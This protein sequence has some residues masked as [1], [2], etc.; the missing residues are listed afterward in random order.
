M[1]RFL[2]IPSIL[3]ILSNSSCAE[4]PPVVLTDAA[5][6]LHADCLVIDGHNDLPWELR[7]L[8]G[9]AK[10]DLR[11]P[12]PKLQTDLPRLR[13]GGLGAQ[14]W[15]AWAPVD[16]IASGTAV[17]TTLEQIALI[18]EMVER[19]P[20]DFQFCETVAEIR[21]AHAAG[22]IASLIGVEGGHSI[23]NS[24][25]TL[26]ELYD[27]G[28]RYMTLTHSDSLDWVDSATDDSNVPGGLNAFGE[29]VIAEMNRL[30]MMVDL[31][32]VSAEA[33]TA[34]MK[35]SQAPVIFSHS[36]ARALA[37]HPRNVPDEVL[38]ELPADGGLVMVNFFSGFTVPEAAANYAAQFPLQRKALSATGA[39]KDSLQRE[40]DAY[41][42]AHPM[43][44]GDIHVVL[45]HIEHIIKVAGIDH[46][47]LGSDYDGVSVLPKQLEDVSSYPFLTQ[48]LMDRGYSPADIRKVLGENL[49]RVFAAVEEK[50]VELRATVDGA[51]RSEE[52]KN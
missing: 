25:R 41:R 42:A 49:L 14:F 18:H 5:R 3:L 39:E 46:V 52:A 12:Q 30:G 22:K 2:F 29:E 32:H 50:A 16:T 23:N 17:A 10:V 37:D 19:Y 13:T 4:R 9:Q 28:A 34:A 24:L 36:S 47:G 20:N 40:L 51:G 15:S 43:P 38:R 6:K 44:R 27:R 33:M 48:G 26:R 11:E 7:D 31:S 8:G 45:D 35:A 21:A 1:Q